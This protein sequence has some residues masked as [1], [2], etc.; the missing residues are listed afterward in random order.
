M[1]INIQNTEKYIMN[2]SNL[3]PALLNAGGQ[4]MTILLKNWERQKG[5]DG[6]PLKRLNKNYAD[7]K[8]KTGRN[9]IRDAQFT[10]QLT[11]SINVISKGE[12]SVAITAANT[13]RSGSG[14]TNLQV[15]EK[16]VDRDDN[17]MGVSQEMRKKAFDTIRNEI[18][19]GIA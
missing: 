16:N 18:R 4:V 17:L 10:G 14:S 15:L 7:Y 1:K 8:K 2:V 6:S 5:G 3:K 9:P 13:G 12:Y 11:Q 19:R